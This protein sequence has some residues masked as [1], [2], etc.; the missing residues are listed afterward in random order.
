MTKKMIFILSALLM[1]GLSMPVFADNLQFTGKLIIPD[2]T[3]NHNNALIVDWQ[4]VEI[5]SLSK[6]NTGYHEKEVV[7]PLDCPYQWGKPKLKIIADMHTTAGEQG[8][9]TTK[10]NEGLL[11]YLRTGRGQPWISNSGQYYDIPAE[12]ISGSGGN[13]ALKLY[14]Y[15]GRYKE[16]ADLTPG[17]FRASANM[18]VRYD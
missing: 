12:G 13:T 2:C 15:L 10:Y 1:S 7:V 17:P 9:K 3:V 11:I 16:I 5:Q 18:E 4:D 6:K 14:A 8:I